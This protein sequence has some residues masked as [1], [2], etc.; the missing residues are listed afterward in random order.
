MWPFR[1]KKPR[2]EVQVTVEATNTLAEDPLMA[3]FIKSRRRTKPI[4]DRHFALMEKMQQ[5]YYRREVD[6][7]EPAIKLCNAMIALAPEAMAAFK[8]DHHKNSESL[9]KSEFSNLREYAAKEFQGPA[10]PGFQQLAIIRER[11]KKFEEVIRLCQHAE[12]QGWAGDWDVRIA[13]CQKKLS[14]TQRT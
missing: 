8:L 3:E 14:K 6:G 11:Q 10:H 9:R 12:S 2:D 13:R 4:L 7:L 1:E 5:A